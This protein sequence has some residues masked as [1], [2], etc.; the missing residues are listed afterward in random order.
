MQ[1]CTKTTGNDTNGRLT[2]DILQLLHSACVVLK[3]ERNHVK[4]WVGVTLSI[5][6]FYVLENTKIMRNRI[7]AM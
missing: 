3:P 5:V 7:F 6:P 2:C 4:A 1:L